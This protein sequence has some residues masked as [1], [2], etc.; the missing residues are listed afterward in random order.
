MVGERRMFV[1]PQHVVLLVLA[2]M[3]MASAGRAADRSCT[4]TTPAIFERVSPAVLFIDATSINPYRVTDRV[5]HTIGSGFLIDDQGLVLTNSHVAFGRQSLVVRMDD[6]TSVPAQLIGADPIFDIAV[7]EI[8]KPT[9]GTLPTIKL[10]NSDDVRVG[11]DVLTVGNLLGLDQTLTHGMVSAVNRILPVTFFSLQEPLIQVDSPINHGNSGGPLLDRCGE[12]IGVRTAIIPD[13]QNI[14][15]AIPIN[16]VKAVLPSLIQGGHV[17]RPWLGFHGQFVDDSLKS[18]LRIPLE[19][20]FLIEVIEPGS[21]A[22]QAKL[23]GG[24][25]ELTVGG[26]D[27]LLGGD[28][29]N[30]DERQANRR[31]GRR[32][33]RAAGAEG[34]RRGQPDPL[35]PRQVSGGEV[36]AARAPASAGR[37]SGPGCR[38]AGLEP[39]ATGRS[40]RLVLSGCGGRAQ[41]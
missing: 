35:S 28:I 27:F 37:H 33:R 13:A 6:G 15:L 18:L 40:T 21:P 32:G 3:A 9:S 34:R 25:Q 8:P 12:A 5:E 36:H 1:P 38:D 10:G 39:Q 41:H 31:A 19:T 4:E 29:V 16:L 22:E 30:Q 2:V 7:L 24:S 20:G 23:R 14:G 17:V 11:D 26:D